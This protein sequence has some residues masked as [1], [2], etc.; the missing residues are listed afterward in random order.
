MVPA[1]HDY[2]EALLDGLEP[3]RCAGPD[4]AHEQGHLDRPPGG[5]P[6][7]FQIHGA[8]WSDKQR[9]R[10]SRITVFT[11]RAPTRSYGVELLVLA[12]EGIR[13]WPRLTAPEQRLTVSLL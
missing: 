5:R 1:H 9:Q 2:A 7:H 13:W 12:P 8:G 4:G 10:C 6:A 3:A 11:T